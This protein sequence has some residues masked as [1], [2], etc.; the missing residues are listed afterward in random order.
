MA[1]SSSR[2]GNGEFCRK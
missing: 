1:M 2:K